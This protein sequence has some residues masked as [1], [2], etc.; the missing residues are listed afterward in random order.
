MP[1]LLLLF[2]TQDKRKVKTEKY[3]YLDFQYLFDHLKPELTEN[4]KDP[5]LK[6]LIIVFYSEGI[7]SFR[8]EADTYVEKNPFLGSSANV[9]FT[10]ILD[11]ISLD[12]ENLENFM[13][14]H[15]R[16]GIGARV[17]LDKEN[18]KYFELADEYCIKEDNYLYL[19]FKHIPQTLLQE[20]KVFFDYIF[21]ITLMHEIS[22]HKQIS[23]TYCFT[24]LSY[25]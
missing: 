18:M 8:K 3:G 23:F 12:C 16:C 15:D 4:D 7:D 17:N 20:H 14:K 5:E 2:L 1:E 22:I 19:T 25:S 13:L 10:C 11:Y 6:K 24:I 9:I 21:P